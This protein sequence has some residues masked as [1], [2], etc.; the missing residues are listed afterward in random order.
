MFHDSR[1][2]LMLLL[3]VALTRA[4]HGLCALAKL[5]IYTSPPYYLPSVFAIT[6]IPWLDLQSDPPASLLLSSV[7]SQVLNSVLYLRLTIES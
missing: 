4:Q 3:F 2:R 1:L 5:Y 6:Q 7:L